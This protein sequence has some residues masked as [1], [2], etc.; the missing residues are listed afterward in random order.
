MIAESKKVYTREEIEKILHS[1]V[2]SW[3]KKFPE[4]TLPQLMAIPLIERGNNV[5]ITAPTGSGK[6]LCAFISIISKLLELSEKNMLEN[7]VYAVYIS[8]LRALNNDI[9]KNLREPLRELLKINKSAGNI[10]IGVRTGDTPQKERA[11]MLYSPPHIL[12]TTPETLAIALNANKFRQLLLPDYVIIDEIHDLCSSKRGVHLCISLERLY[13]K[14]KFFRIGL[15]ATIHP[16]EEV[17]KF[18]VGYEN[19]RPRDCKIINASFAKPFELHMVSPSED[20]FEE[21]RRSENKLYATLKSLVEKSR[22]S[23]IFTNTRSG[24]ESVVFHLKNFF[25]IEDIEAH[26]SSLS[27][28]ERL[29]VE[30]MLKNGMLKAVVSSTSLELGIDIGYI[31]QVIQIGSPKS[32]SR[33]LQRIGRSGHRLHETSIGYLIANNH[34]ELVE[35]GVLLK[36]ASRRKI[37][38]VYIPKNC[39]DVLAQHVVGM[40][41]EDRYTL[42]EAYKTITSAYPYRELSY[43]DFMSVMNYLAGNY[44][45][46]ETNKVY[47]KIVMNEHY[48]FTKTMGRVIYS[49]NIGTI[50]DQVAALV[51]TVDKK[52]I[53]TLDE[54]FLEYLSPG[55]KFVLSGRVFEY[56]W[57][58]GMNVYVKPV[59][60]NK[61]TVPSWVSEMLPLSYDLA[62]EVDRYRI[63]I[64]KEILKK[65]NEKR[66]KEKIIKELN[67]DENS[68]KSL[69]SYLKAQ[70]LYL[71]AKG[72]YPKENELIIELYSDVET[73]KLRVIFHSLRGRRVNNCL[74]KAF[75]YYFSHKL[76]QNIE[77]NFSDNGFAINFPLNSK[78][79]I[80]T[81]LEEV[82]KNLRDYVERAIINTELFKRRFRHCA[83]RSLMIVRNYKGF[84]KSVGKQQVSAENIIEALREYPEFPIIKETIREILQD[85]MDIEKAIE[86]LSEIKNVLTFETEIPSPFS[87]QLILDSYADIILMEDRK[88]LLKN[89]YEK[90]LMAVYKKT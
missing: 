36:H 37:D 54:N 64:M 82:K 34:D 80:L 76:N 75:G 63:S 7:R 30:N 32:I 72:I 57:S 24:T 19:C 3:L 51:Y 44:S 10:R 85:H 68:A 6:T 8:P 67:C 40:G 86:Y 12:I 28:E 89:L 70:G 18:L 90:V 65:A 78:I 50:P 21:H 42:E 84:T 41:A 88:K 55:E 33:C 20:L 73:K 47:S 39:L 31:D 45:K 13:R 87:H 14:V 46:L 26:H 66:I 48:F 74:S 58:S 79:E 35:I 53:G 43:N 16:L 61:P 69:I 2:V 60:D 38:S 1:D 15:S 81:A 5:L 62:K 17:A 27:R 77:L 83:T 56:L 25:N 52:L 4:L 22:T 11:R 29:R 71:K 23:L 49:T 9:E 59:K